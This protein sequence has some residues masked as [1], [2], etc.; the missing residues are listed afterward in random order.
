M[1]KFKIEF[2]QS[3]TFIVDVKAKTEAEAIELAE[4]LLA[5]GQYEDQYDLQT[6]VSGTYDVTNTDDPFN[7]LN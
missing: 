5:E 3:E 2:T 6:V 4:K 1:N 7:P